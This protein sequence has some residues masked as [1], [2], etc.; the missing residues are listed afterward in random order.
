MTKSGSVLEGHPSASCLPRLQAGLKPKGVLVWREKREEGQILG[1]SHRAHLVALP[2][3]TFLG[4][5]TGLHLSFFPGAFHSR[6]ACVWVCV[7]V[8]DKEGE[9]EITY[10]QA[11]VCGNTWSG[12]SSSISS[13]LID[14]ASFETQS[15]SILASLASL[16]VLRNTCHYL[17]GD[18]LTFTWVQAVQTPVLP[19]SSE[20]GTACSPSRTHESV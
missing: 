11:H 1:M 17:L 13:Y 7:C 20:C 18:C 19:F 16:L 6:H 12:V 14:L 15:S 3:E 9:G 2:E 8:Y 10:L 4:S 5:G